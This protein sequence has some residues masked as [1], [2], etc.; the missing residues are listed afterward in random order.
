[1]LKCLDSFVL[2]LIKKEISKVPLTRRLT[3]KTLKFKIIKMFNIL[4]NTNL[5]FKNILETELLLFLV[6]YFLF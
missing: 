1:M 5:G 6:N 4:I 2:F 3:R